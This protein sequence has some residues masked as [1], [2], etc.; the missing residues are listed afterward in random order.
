[1]TKPASNVPPWF[2]LLTPVWFLALTS[3]SDGLWLGTAS[4][5][6]PFLPQIA[7]F[8]CFLHSRQKK[9]RTHARQTPVMASSACSE[10][11]LGICKLNR[12]LFFHLC[13]FWIWIEDSKPNAKGGCFNYLKESDFCDLELIV[14]LIIS[15]K[16][17]PSESTEEAFGSQAYIPVLSWNC[18]VVLGKGVSLSGS[19]THQVGTKIFLMEVL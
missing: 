3:L 11:S 10:T 4:Q 7:C 1:M 18:L 17:H 19:Y 12:R 13:T 16:C 9:T 5:I 14:A 2:L 8:E 15:E 6:D